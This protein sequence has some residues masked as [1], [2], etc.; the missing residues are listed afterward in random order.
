L[1]RA[2]A[3]ALFVV[4]NTAHAFHAEVQRAIGIPWA[5]LMRLVAAHIRATHAPGTRVGILATD[6]TLTARLYEEALEAE[7][8][9]PV[10]PVPGSPTQQQVMAAIGDPRTGI[11][12]TGIEVSPQAREQLARAARWCMEQGAGV[13]V[14]GCTEISVAF[15]HDRPPDMPLVDPLRVLADAVLDLAWGER[16]PASLLTGVAAGPGAAVGPG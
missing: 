2:G 12:S 9:K 5:H 4:C 3:D 15:A 11:K 16:T 10:A 8:L 7:G 14:P 1:E 6:G 13:I